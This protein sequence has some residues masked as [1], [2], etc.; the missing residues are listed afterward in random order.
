MC[1]YLRDMASWIDHD[2]GAHLQ[3]IF[4]TTNSRLFAS[5]RETET[6]VLTF[7]Y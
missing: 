5:M 7:V 3:E 1:V 6:S 2:F 4:M